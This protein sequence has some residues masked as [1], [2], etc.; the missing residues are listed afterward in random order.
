MHLD[1]ATLQPGTSFY[2]DLNLFDVRKREVLA[3]FVLAFAQ[4]AREGLGPRHGAVE[5]IA[6]EQ[7]DENHFPMTKLYDGVSLT[8]P[9]TPFIIDLA[10]QMEPAERL[11][12]RFVTPTEL[13]GAQQRAVRPEFGVVMAR[14]RDRIST[15]R[16]LYGD[17]PLELDFREFGG[18]AAEIRLKRCDVRLVHAERRSS[19]TGQTHSLGGFVGEAEYEGALTEFIPYLRAG[20]WTGVG[21][22]TVW[23]KGEILMLH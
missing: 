6:V 9:E 3:Y 5:L 18:R 11:R 7:L 10:R 19:R 21:R 12:I 16:G 15:L 4:L 23:G 8:P 2:F 17:G 1:G 13:K 22:Q 14:L 20:Q